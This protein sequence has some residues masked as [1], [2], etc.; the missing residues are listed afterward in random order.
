MPKPSLFAVVYAAKSTEDKHG[1]LP[2]QRDDC[3][4]L[5]EREGEQVAAEYSDEGFSAYT[6]S[7]GPGLEAAKAHAEQ[8]A[9]EHGEAVLVVQH[10]DRLARGAGDGPG[11]PAHLAEVMFWANR[12]SVQLR[13]VQ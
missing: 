8:L 7:R 2:T 13:S 1:S 11:A 5:M 6:R 12:H 10:S 9:A 3:R 4:T